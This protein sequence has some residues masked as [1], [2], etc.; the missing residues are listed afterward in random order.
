MACPAM[1]IDLEALEYEFNE[2]PDERGF[3]R[4]SSLAA[5]L[6]AT[7]CISGC[8]ASA[9]APAVMPPDGGSPLYKSRR[10]LEL[11]FTGQARD[12]RSMTC[13]PA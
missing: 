13:C 4:L 10:K 12:V 1:S 11:E 2:P 3:K 6:S 7:L 8:S 5:P 9:A